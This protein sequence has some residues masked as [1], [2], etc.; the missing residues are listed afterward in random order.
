MPVPSIYICLGRGASRH[1]FTTF[2]GYVLAVQ[3]IIM[4]NMYLSLQWMTDNWKT[5]PKFAKAGVNGSLCSILHYLSTV[6]YL[7]FHVPAMLFIFPELGGSQKH[8]IF[9]SLPS[10]IYM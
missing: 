8:H 1:W 4:L 2:K 9:N 3:R 7:D 5:D 10:I 6:R